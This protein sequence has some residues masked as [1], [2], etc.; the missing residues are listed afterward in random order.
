MIPYGKQFID[1][2]DIQAIVDT[3]KCK[4]ITTGP[5][6][7]EFEQSVCDY[8]GANYGVAVSSGT[9]A[10]HASMF[11]IGINPGDEVIVP[12]ITFVATANCVVYQGGKP[13]FC[14]IDPETLLIDITKIKKLITKN[15][16]AII[17]VDYAGMPCDYNALR[18]ITDKHNLFLISDACHSIGAIKP[19]AD[20][21][22]YSFHPVK[23]ITTGEGGM[24]VTNDIVLAEKMRGF[25]NHGMIN[26]SMYNLGYNYRITDFQC[27]L[28]ITQLEKLNDWIIKRKEIADKYN[29][30]L[31]V[32]RL[33]KG[34]NHVYH[35]YVVKV[36]DRDN[37]KQKLFEKGVG[38]QIHYRPVYY[39]PYHQKFK[40]DCPEAENVYNEILSLPIYP[41]LTIEQQDYVIECLEGLI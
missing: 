1:E 13:V 5:K 37:I 26:G 21:T 32:K 19:S 27:A 36:S 39:H 25:R 33:R 2:D 41:G 11:A 9:A 17:A 22:C 18:K 23:H 20:I 29:K 16:K 14:D 38:T 30:Q 28:G 31:T 8:V 7:E 24:A 4:L 3:L 34:R 6:V 12:A 15:T 10:L 40:I 35:L